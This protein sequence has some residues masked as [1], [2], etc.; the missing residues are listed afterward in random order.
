MH[1]LIIT[2]I[3]CFLE[4]LSKYFDISKKE[5]QQIV[6]VTYISFHPHK[7]LSQEEAQTCFTFGTKTYLNLPSA[8]PK[9]AF[10]HNPVKLK[11]NL[12]LICA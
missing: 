10:T 6:I 1:H 9:E 11:A 2:Q 3:N 12:L 4:S 7:R 5:I 8:S